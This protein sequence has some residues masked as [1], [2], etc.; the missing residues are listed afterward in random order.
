MDD[1]T[2]RFASAVGAFAG[3]W[4]SARN[5][6]GLDFTEQKLP[7]QLVLNEENMKS[8]SNWSLI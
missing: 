2:A 3:P 6:V 4:L 5:H 8:V 7:V 1:K